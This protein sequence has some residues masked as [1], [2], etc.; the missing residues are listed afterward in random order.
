MSALYWL[1]GQPF[2]YSRRLCKWYRL[3]CHPSR[4]LFHGSVDLKEKWDNVVRLKK[5]NSSNYL[6]IHNA[7]VPFKK[8]Q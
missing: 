8:Q 6:R 7:I 4:F 2:L 3:L 1:F 5:V